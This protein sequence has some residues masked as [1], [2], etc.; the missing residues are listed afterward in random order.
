MMPI[1]RRLYPKCKKRTQSFATCK[2]I[3]SSLL[4]T[5]SGCDEQNSSESIMA[6]I[7][8]YAHLDNFTCWKLV[9]HGWN[10]SHCEQMP[11][12]VFCEDDGSPHDDNDTDDERTTPSKDESEED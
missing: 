2:E 6:H 5:M 4:T 12:E 3:C 11:Q 8:K 9:E 1:A 10:F 7:W